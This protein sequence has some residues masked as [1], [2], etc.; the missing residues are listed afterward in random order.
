MENCEGIILKG[1]GGLYTVKT[2]GELFTCKA[3]GLFRKDG[4]VPL[5]GDRVSVGFSGQG[6][7]LIWNILSRKNELVRP[8]IANIDRLFIVFSVKDPA[9]NLYN[10]DR[11]IAIAEYKGIEPCIVISKVDLCDGREYAEVYEKA[12]FT[13]V[14]VSSKT[15]EG[16]DRL[17][18]ELFGKVSAF[19]GNS[20]VGKSTLLNALFANLNL[21]TGEISRKLQR[22]RHTTRHLELFPIEEGGFVADTPGFSSIDFEKGIVI[23]RHELPGCFRE[24]SEYINRCRFTSCTHTED[25]GCAVKDAVERGEISPARY[26][27]YL[28]MYDEVRNVREWEVR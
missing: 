24:F 16:L 21:P 27:S 7:P 23:L 20:G 19:A 3:R 1:V 13:V 18:K 15:G 8:P 26:K 2:A 6:V 9:P 12:G 5:V 10:L 25:E 11:L 22:G 14:E 4:K 28:D 17:K